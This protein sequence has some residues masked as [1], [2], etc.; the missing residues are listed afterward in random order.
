[1]SE[2]T[3]IAKIKEEGVTRKLV[4]LT[5]DQKSFPRHGYDVTIDGK[6]IGYITSGTVSPVLGKPIALAYVEKEY[7][8]EGTEVNIKIRDKEIPVQIVKLPFVVK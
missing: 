8:Q 6:K 4:P 7:A 5:T 3:V 2:E 1:M